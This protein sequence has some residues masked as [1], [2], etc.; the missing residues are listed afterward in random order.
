[1]KKLIFLICLGVS[2]RAGIIEL[3]DEIADSLISERERFFSK[4]FDV[5]YDKSKIKL[6]SKGLEF[7]DLCKYPPSGYRFNCSSINNEQIAGIKKYF[8]HTENI[9]KAYKIF[10]NSNK[11]LQKTNIYDYGETKSNRMME[12]VIIIFGTSACVDC[13][14]RI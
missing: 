8:I 6:D 14:Q 11:E 9:Q 1:M 3:N 5:V 2:L 4:V 13:M 10:N 7:I 12:W